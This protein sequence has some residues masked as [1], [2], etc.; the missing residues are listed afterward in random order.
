MSSSVFGIT[1]D[2]HDAKAIATFWSAALGRPLAEGADENG[3]EIEADPAVPG[4][5]I[6]F[7]RVPEVKT[8]KNRMHLDLVAH[9]DLDS[10]V[11]RLIGL[12]ATKLNEINN[13]IRFVTM[14]DI[15]GNEFDVA[16][17]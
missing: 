4:S 13:R 16:A 2:A 9:G 11:E 1:I 6:G 10:E 17:V 3:A 15:E 7:R 5:R 14:A 8:V 12:G